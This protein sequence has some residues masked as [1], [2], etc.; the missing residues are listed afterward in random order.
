LEKIDETLCSVT[1]T[2]DIRFIGEVLA[3]IRYGHDA[4]QLRASYKQLLTAIAAFEGADDDLNRL[5]HGLDRGGLKSRFDKISAIRRKA[6]KRSAFY[7]ATLPQLMEYHKACRTAFIHLSN[8]RLSEGGYQ[9]DDGVF[10]AIGS[11][12]TSDSDG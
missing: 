2:R 7:E 12:A 10:I 3:R 8:E 4:L 5:R 9:I 1:D 11:D 6:F